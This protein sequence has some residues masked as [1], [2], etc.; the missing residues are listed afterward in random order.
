MVYTG[1]VKDAGTDSEIKFILFG[2][3]GQSEEIKLDKDDER[4]ERSS[5]D[6]IRLD[7]DDVGNPTKIRVE[8]N[9]K[10]MR[11]DW[12]L[13]KVHWHINVELEVKCRQTEISFLET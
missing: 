5:V 4:F 12:F 10:G 8:I 6:A 7:I 13:A 11:P 2:D 1:D 9:G 3:E